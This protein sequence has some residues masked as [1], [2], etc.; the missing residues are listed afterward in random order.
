M[1]SADM[2]AVTR[3]FAVS[4][5]APCTA[6][7]LYSQYPAKSE[8]IACL[9]PETSDTADVSLSPRCQIAAHLSHHVAMLNLPPIARDQLGESHKKTVDS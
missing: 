2:P 1:Q 5:N 9:I 8:I 4:V 3:K 7:K 6:Y